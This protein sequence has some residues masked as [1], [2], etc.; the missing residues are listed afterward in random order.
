V[1][2]RTVRKSCHPV[3]YWTASSVPHLY[4]LVKLLLVGF[5]LII[6]GFNPFKPVVVQASVQ[7]VKVEFEIANG[8]PVVFGTGCD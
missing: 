2:F 3:F 4:Q 8:D 1:G 7:P 6:G 5:R